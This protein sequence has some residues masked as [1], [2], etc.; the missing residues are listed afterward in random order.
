MVL[1]ESY[2]ALNKH[3][4]KDDVKNLSRI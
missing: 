3:I 1:Y 4:K 2:I